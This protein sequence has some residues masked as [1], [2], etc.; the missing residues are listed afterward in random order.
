MIQKS[1]YDPRFC[2]CA[3]S[4]STWLSV[5]QLTTYLN[6]WPRSFQ[7]ITPKASWKG[8]ASGELVLVEKK[9]VSCTVYILSKGRILNNRIAA[10]NTSRAQTY[11]QSLAL[12]FSRSC[13]PFTMRVSQ[14]LEIACASRNANVTTPLGSCVFSAVFTTSGYDPSKI[15]M[16]RA[17]PDSESDE[18]SI[19]GGGGSGRSSGFLRSMDVNRTWAYCR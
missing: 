17:C 18:T 9:V 1:S 19:W 15:A 8:S 10:P 3:N 13:S 11:N 4:C 5:L 16:S 14:A 12:A 7:S 2:P 6:I